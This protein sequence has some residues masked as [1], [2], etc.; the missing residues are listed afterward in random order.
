M[1]RM[2]LYCNGR[3]CVSYNIISEQN[4]KLW[5]IYTV[6]IYSEDKVMKHIHWWSQIDVFLLRSV[7]LDSKQDVF[8]RKNHITESN[9]I[10][11]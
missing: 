11:W 1:K 7:G 9:T 2:W 6:K 3:M 10:V 4:N 5:K 8:S